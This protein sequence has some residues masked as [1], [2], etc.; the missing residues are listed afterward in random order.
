MS[1]RI[2]SMIIHLRPHAVC[3]CLSRTEKIFVAIR[4]VKS[5]EKFE[6]FEAFERSVKF[7]LTD[8]TDLTDFI[9][10]LS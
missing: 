4:Y 9:V 3:N 5:F 7:S 6:K 8:L 1:S 2:W 10:I